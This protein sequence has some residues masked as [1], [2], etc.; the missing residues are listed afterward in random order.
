MLANEIKPFSWM[1][2]EMKSHLSTKLTEQEMRDLDR[3]ART[4]LAGQRIM[5]NAIKKHLESRKKTDE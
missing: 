2:D 5:I 4:N 3:S 1:D